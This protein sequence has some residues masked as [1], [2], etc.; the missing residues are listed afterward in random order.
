MEGI[1]DILDSISAHTLAERQ[2]YIRNKS[3]ARG[4]VTTKD[5]ENMTVWIVNRQYSSGDDWLSV[6]HGEY[7]TSKN[8]RWG[9][10]LT[11]HFQGDYY[12]M[13]HD[14]YRPRI[15]KRIDFTI[16]NSASYFNT[17][18]IDQLR[19]GISGEKGWRFF[20]TI[21][22]AYNAI[23]AGLEKL[24]EIQ[25]KEEEAKKAIEEAARRAKEE[26]EKTAALE[27]QRRQEEELAILEAKKKEVQKELI[28]LEEKYRNACS[29]V[30]QQASLRLNPLI[31]SVQNSVKFSHIYDG[32]CVVVEGGPGTGKTTTLIQR[33]KYLISRIDLEDNIIN[34]AEIKISNEQF[35]IVMQD[36]GDWLFFSP[37]ELLRMYLRDAMNEEGLKDTE[38]R[39]AVWNKH[40]RKILRD[41]YHLIG[42][43]CPFGGSSETVPMFN[44]NESGIIRDVNRSFVLQIVSDIR[45]MV[46][47]DSSKYSWRYIGE[48]V[49]KSAKKL[50]SVNDLSSLVRLLISFSSL[51]SVSINGVNEVESIMA[52]YRWM[53]SEL[54]SAIM[55]KIQ[56]DNELYSSLRSL[57]N[58]DYQ[59]K[60]EED[61]DDEEDEIDSFAEDKLKVASR[62]R[63][64]LKAAAV[65]SLDPNFKLSGLNKEFFERTKQLIKEEDLRRIGELALFDKRIRPLIEH[66]DRF[67]F[68]R[69]PRL[70]KSYRKDAYS[71][72]S[73]EWN[74]ELLGLE[75][76]AEKRNR[77]LHT[78]EQALLLGLINNIALR[79][80]KSS[81]RVF[82]SLN[83]KYIDAYKTVVKPVIGV[84]EATDYS[85]VDFYA[86]ASLRHYLVSSITLAGDVMQGLTVNGIKDWT[87]LYDDDIFPEM[88]ITPLKTSYRQS[89]TLLSLAQRLYKKQI[90][91]PAPYKSYLEGSS[92]SVPRPLWFES[93]DDSRKA[94]WLIDRI[95]EVKAK[96]TFVPSIAIFVEDSVAAAKLTEELLSFETLQDEGIDVADCSR[97]DTLSS[98][99]T[100][101]IFPIALVKGME[102]E[103]AFFH[104]IDTLKSEL[105][106]RYLY[107]GL[108]R[109]AFFLGV[110]SSSNNSL[111]DSVRDLFS[112]G[113]WRQI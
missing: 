67:I 8:S 72:K 5:G 18:S 10:I 113:N 87:D 94:E 35:D 29:F 21:N 78:Q 36:G 112:D 95:L 59:V 47:V 7:T 17:P 32:T 48:R 34:D 23:R 51:R 101:R 22:E 90:G 91:Y 69:I 79:F 107:V 20:H 58:K 70:Y 73:A 108:S 98:R 64:M 49:K 80:Y 50:D 61:E 56:E 11:D 13:G 81:P 16:N 65:N 53:I 86:I 12:C 33:L 82:E 102:F 106:E 110:T 62:L 76:S 63:A 68:N 52:R 26:E 75:V 41:Y 3:I 1:K 96:Y 14:K 40:L 74:H 60:S 66:P 2:H 15:A 57:I 88:D 28:D 85:V 100:V 24:Q 83:H 111:L 44:G 71:R 6:P 54:S 19:V 99:D 77:P 92:E 105:V 45:K 30:R 31:D 4:Q 84:D 27:E 89:P 46:E 25:R 93:N 37:T 104:N 9:Q 39:T 42:N 109:A 38:N 97:G 103:V 55:V 43:E